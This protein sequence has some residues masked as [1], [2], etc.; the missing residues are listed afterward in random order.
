MATLFEI[1][2]D[3]LALA[4]LSTLLSVFLLEVHKSSLMSLLL[5]DRIAR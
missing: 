5:H 3:Y 2:C 4:E 1:F